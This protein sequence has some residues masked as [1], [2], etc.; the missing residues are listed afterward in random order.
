MNNLLDKMYTMRFCLSST[1]SQEAG[2]TSTST[3]TS[4]QSQSKMSNNKCICVGYNHVACVFKSKGK[5]R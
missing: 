5:E 2:N 3:I 4:F 1:F